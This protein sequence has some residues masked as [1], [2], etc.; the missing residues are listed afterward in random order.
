MVAT[1]NTSVPVP[2]HFYRGSL[3]DGAALQRFH[4]FGGEQVQ[5]RDAR[6]LGTEVAQAARF[7]GEN[8]G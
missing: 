6:C 4:H 3:G 8:H 5:E 7:D 1:S 2:D